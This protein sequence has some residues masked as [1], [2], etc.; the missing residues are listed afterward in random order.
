MI[1]ISPNFYISLE[2]CSLFHCEHHRITAVP[3]SSRCSEHY[4]EQ[5]A[6][7]G[8]GVLVPVLLVSFGLER[9]A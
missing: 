7:E 6:E 3:W 4:Q 1:T 9:V 2:K 5:G 8:V